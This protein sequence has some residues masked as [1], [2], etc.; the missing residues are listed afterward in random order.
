MSASS[1]AAAAASSS[2]VVP[3]VATSSLVAVVSTSTAAPVITSTVAPPNTSTAAPPATSAAPTVEI[4]STSTDIPVATSQTSAAP[5]VITSSF[6][7]VQDSTTDSTGAVLG[8]SS[9]SDVGIGGTTSTFS[10][11]P[12]VSS[13]AAL[14]VESTLPSVF[15]VTTSST[16][17]FPDI[18]ALASTSSANAAATSLPRASVFT[19][20]NVNATGSSLAASSTNSDSSGP[21]VGAIVGGIVGAV[22]VLLV[23]LGIFLFYKARSRKQQSEI[24]VDWGT[25]TR[26]RATPTSKPEGVSA[27]NGGPSPADSIA[28]SEGLLE[29][30]KGKEPGGSLPRVGSAY[31]PVPLEEKDLPPPPPTATGPISSAQGVPPPVR[32]SSANYVVDPYAQQQFYDV[33]QQYPQ[34]YQTPQEFMTA[35]GTARYPGYYDEFGQYH[36]FNAPK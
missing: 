15:F 4:A 3:T 5:V 34:Q 2:D 11:L 26:R 23:A 29:A 17:D 8:S 22:V 32:G 28:A 18:T 13:S 12:P 20:V 31:Q 24:V 21:S 7:Q 35:Q 16:T 33:N 14:P 10:N 9:A 36:Y 25:G 1:S 27:R 6:A 30:G 19:N